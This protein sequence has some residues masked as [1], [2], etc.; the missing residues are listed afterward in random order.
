MSHPRESKLG[1]SK[2]NEVHTITSFYA[3]Y[4]KSINLIFIAKE[5]SEENM[6]QPIS[7]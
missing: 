3:F 5:I 2:L 4:H 7:I 6:T 1:S